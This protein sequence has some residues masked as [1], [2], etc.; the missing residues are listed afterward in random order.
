M[1]RLDQHFSE[2]LDP[3]VGLEQVRLADTKENRVSTC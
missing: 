1:K 2:G 3:K